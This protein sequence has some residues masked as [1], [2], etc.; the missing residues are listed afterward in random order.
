MVGGFKMEW[1]Y[2]RVLVTGGASFISSH[3]VDKLAALGAKITVVDNLSSRKLENLAD[4][5]KKIQQQQ[6]QLAKFHSCGFAHQVAQN[7]GENSLQNIG[8]TVGRD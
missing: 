3:L 7:L 5:I 1:R 4:S 2:I 6:Q 8:Q